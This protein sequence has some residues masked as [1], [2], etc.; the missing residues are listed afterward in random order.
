M[1]PVTPTS[2]AIH[3][4]QTPAMASR[5]AEARRRACTV[6]SESNSIPTHDWALETSTL[7][8]KHAHPP[9]LATMPRRPRPPWLWCSRQRLP[10]SC[11]TW[12]KRQASPLVHRPL[13][14]SRHWGCPPAVPAALSSCLKRHAAPRLHVPFWKSLQMGDA[15]VSPCG[16]QTNRAGVRKAGKQRWSEKCKQPAVGWTDAQRNTR[17]AGCQRGMRREEDQCKRRC[18]KGLSHAAKRDGRL[19]SQVSQHFRKQ[20]V[21]IAR[22]GAA[23]AL[24]AQEGARRGDGSMQGLGP[25]R[26]EDRKS[27]RHNRGRETAGRW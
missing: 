13:R 20:A 23:R 25:S 9:A 3:A 24:A 18:E 27:T 15:G 21:S 8:R 26:S 14:K 6:A 22:E 7:S 2:L 19:G 1:R 11:R 4:A 17:R 16:R 12:L 10:Y 5:V